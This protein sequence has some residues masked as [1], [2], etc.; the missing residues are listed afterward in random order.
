M[1]LK[2]AEGLRV[3]RSDT[4]V[5]LAAEGEEVEMTEYWH[6]RLRD[7]DVVQ[8]EAPVA[9]ESESE[10]DVEPAIHGETP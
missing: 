9:A 8:A 3:L 6:R 7:G 2:P 10:A 1:F 5:P 4:R